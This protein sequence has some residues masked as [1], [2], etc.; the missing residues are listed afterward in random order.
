MPARLCTVALTD[1]SGVRHTVEVSA[2]SVFEAAALGLAAMK[3]EAWVD[4]P[5]RAAKLQ[6]TVVGPVVRHEVA[7]ERV[8]AWLDGVTTSPTDLLKKQRLKAMFG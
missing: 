7:V 6:V 1:P 4:G 8:L 3:R 5:G 2:E